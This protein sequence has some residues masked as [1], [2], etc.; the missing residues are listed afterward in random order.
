VDTQSGVNG[1]NQCAVQLVGYSPEEVMGHSLVKEF[2]R[3]EHQEMVQNVLSAALRG[4][5]TANFDFPLMTKS[6]ARREILPNATVRRDE[7]GNIIG[8]GEFGHASQAN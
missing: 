7:Y 8:S 2:I 4:D 6:G 1:W 5:E 3:P